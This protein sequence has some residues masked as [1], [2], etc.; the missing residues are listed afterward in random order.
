VPAVKEYLQL[1]KPS[2]FQ[3]KT[4]QD[5]AGFKKGNILNTIAFE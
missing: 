2:Q 4:Q 3:A 5:M 1:P